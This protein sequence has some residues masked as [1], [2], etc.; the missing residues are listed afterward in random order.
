MFFYSP[1]DTQPEMDWSNYM[2]V[3]LIVLLTVFGVLGSLASKVAPES[4]LLVVK[5]LKSFS[6]Y[7]NFVKIV[8]VPKTAEN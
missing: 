6:F 3:G 1:V 2:A 4:R 5:V 7:D 8:H